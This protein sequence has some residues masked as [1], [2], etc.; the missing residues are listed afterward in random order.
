MNTNVKAGCLYM[1]NTFILITS[2]WNATF[3]MEAR[4][5]VRLVAKKYNQI[6]LVNEGPLTIKIEEGWHMMTQSCSQV[7]CGEVGQIC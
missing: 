6:N 7:G 1:I 4:Q 3:S 5:T 2:S